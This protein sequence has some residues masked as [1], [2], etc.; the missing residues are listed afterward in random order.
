[1]FARITLLLCIS[2]FIVTPKGVFAQS[3]SVTFARDTLEA[4]VGKTFTNSLV[5]HNAGPGRQVVNLALQFPKSVQLLST[6]PPELHLIP[7][8]TAMIPIKGLLT[9][10]DNPVANRVVIQLKDSTDR[11]LKTVTFALTVTEKPQPAV[12]LS[13]PDEPILL[14]S[15]SAP[16]RLTVR[17]MHTRN[18]PAPYFIDVTS[19]PEGLDR[20]PF[21][22]TIELGPRQD[23]TLSIPINPQRYWS[24]SAPYELIL[25][26]RD[27]Q[28]S[29]LGSVVYKL[30]IAVDS[31]RYIAANAPGNGG[32][33]A[34]VGITKLSDGQWAREARVWGTD[35][36]GKAQLDFQVQ[37]LDYIGSN[38]Q[39]L[40]NSF[41]SLRINRAMV[42]LGSSYDFHELSL[43][44][45]G[46]KV[47]LIQPDHQWTF[48][49]INSNPNWLAPGMNARAGSVYSA[50]YD[51]RLTSL[52]G[53]S[54]SASSSYFTQSNT[55]RV[56]YLNFASF[57]Y[58]QPQRH[59]L[60][61]LA[62]RSVEFVRQG[63]DQARTVGWAGQ[64]SYSYIVPRFSW[65]FRT[66]LSSP[67][68]SGLQK[69]AT[70]INGQL[71]WQASAGTTLAARLN[72][73]RYN[74][75]WFS[76]ATDSYRRLFGSTIAEVSLSHQLHQF[77]LGLR[78]YWYAQTDF[79]VTT[80][81]QADAYRLAPSLSYSRRNGQHID[82]S[83]DIGTFY[84]R[85]ET[86]GQPGFLSQ[87]IVS[88]LSLGPFSFWGYWQ[89]GPYYLLDL[90]TRQPAQILTTSLTPMI[91]FVLLNRRLLGS[92]GVNYLYDAFTA[93]S[94]YI[95]IGRVQF[96]L[97]PTCTM[98][99]A[100]YGMPYSPRPELAFSQYR[101]D[102]TK[103]FGQLQ[104]GHRGQLQLSF[105]EDANGNHSKDAGERWM[106]SLLVTINENTLITNAKGSISY[107]NL[108]LG[109]YTISA[110][111]A[112]RVGDPMLYQEK[113][114]LVRSLTKVIALSPTFRVKGQLRCQA[115][116]YDRQPC[117]F[118]RF[119]IDIQRDDQTISS[120]TPLPNGTFAVH[121]S[122]GTYTILVRDYG[123]QQQATVKTT[124]FTLT[125]TGDHPVFDWT[126]DASTRPVEVK[127][128]KAE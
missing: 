52:P 76:S 84:D 71:T 40:Q 29:V 124:A 46:L 97:T 107:R 102:V 75:I 80:G 79:S 47:S 22:L 67:V 110:I 36:V 63:S 23:T 112:S 26:V 34:S 126:V 77:T 74:Q 88:S 38:Y 113:L 11:L 49:A 24:V 32:Y 115:N 45:R 21:P 93:A 5:L 105:F 56:G 65:Q 120:T 64:L 58:N 61:V 127:R 18:N 8:E 86:S 98:R 57:R 83:Y 17:L 101:L 31:K 48:W 108:P 51:Q 10:H 111:S 19:L 60:E 69:G 70:L 7:G 123:R 37:Y 50:R 25:T 87:R 4:A 103:R 12:S 3:L 89:K 90:Q 54:W 30:V 118:S 39:Q 14:Y 73:A 82:L 6:F 104:A 44:G 42:R 122:P 1:M 121:L 106:D 15:S 13:A 53:G 55:M 72:H 66:Y 94:R 20:T 81:Q 109:T 95:G 35:S 114:T 28:Q 116:A 125:E 92:V 33:A 27:Q 2:I 78:P 68:Y 59:S 43:L 117:Q 128:F 85:S 100:G 16:A 91:D 9:T 41:I 62:G 119:I 96:D 99:L